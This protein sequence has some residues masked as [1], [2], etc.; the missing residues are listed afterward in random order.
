MIT[1]KDTTPRPPKPR[2]SPVDFKDALLVAGL[3]SLL[4]GIAH[5]SP[6]I[7]AIVFGLFCLTA[8]LRPTRATKERQS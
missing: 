4:G 1:I 7:A 8:A 3:V 5:F 6:A 2:Q